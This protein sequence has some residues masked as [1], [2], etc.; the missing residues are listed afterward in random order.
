[1]A[2]VIKYHDD[3]RKDIFM[4]IELVAKAVMVTMGP[5]GKNVLLEKSYG[6]PKVTND[7]VTIA[8]EIEFED[9]YYNIGAQLVKEAADNTVKLAGDGT[10]TT[11]VLTYAMAKEGLR[12]I[13]AGVN[14][15]SL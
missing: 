13:R 6:A 4:G 15:F 5:K 12:Y 1:M 11:T 9:K 2:K 8:K 10:T 7:G 14:P 3:A